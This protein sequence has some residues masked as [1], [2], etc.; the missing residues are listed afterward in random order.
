MDRSLNVTASDFSLVADGPYKVVIDCSEHCVFS[1]LNFSR[2]S[3]E[4]LTMSHC[5]V[6]AAYGL[7]FHVQGVSFLNGKL[8]VD[9]FFESRL[10][11][12]NN[13]SNPQY[14]YGAEFQFRSCKAPS[15]VSL[16]SNILLSHKILLVLDCTRS[17]QSIGVVAL[18]Y[19]E[20]EDGLTS[21]LSC[22]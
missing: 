4:N 5:D 2:V 6:K 7:E 3:I 8:A 10:N 21:R 17:L 13:I 11:G 9:S 15:D 16:N 1:L 12:H 14:G 18:G 20:V 19:S 22:H